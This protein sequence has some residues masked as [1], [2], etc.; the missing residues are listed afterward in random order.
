MNP[1][2]HALNG[3]R[4]NGDEWFQFGS[5]VFVVIIRIEEIFLCRFIATLVAIKPEGEK[6]KQKFN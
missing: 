3:A 4:Y 1:L 6:Y 5:L 2:G